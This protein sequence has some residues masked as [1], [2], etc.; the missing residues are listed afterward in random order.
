[1][2]K[3]T[4]YTEVPVSERMPEETGWYSCIYG[5][6]LKDFLW[7][8]ATARLF[9]GKIGK[10]NYVTHWL[11][12]KTDQVIMS[13]EDFLKAIGDA[14]DAGENHESQRLFAMKPAPSFT[15]EQYL[16]NLLK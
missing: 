14:Y 5:A 10:V 11:D 2:K 8:D 4:V 6:D 9:F 16:S 15:K 3:Q 7:Y 12:K 13:K 1:M